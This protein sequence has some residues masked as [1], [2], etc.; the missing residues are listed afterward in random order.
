MI[1]LKIN[2]AGDLVTSYHR[3]L[4][5]LKLSWVL[6]DN[7]T[8]NLMFKIGPCST[9]RDSSDNLVSPL[10]LYLTTSTRENIP[11][12]D[13]CYG[14]DE[15]RQLVLLSIRAA[16]RIVCAKHKDITSEA[17]LSEVH[18]A[19]LE[20]VENIL[21]NPSV[22]IKKEHIDENPFSRQNLNVYIYNNNKEIYNFPLEV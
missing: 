17:V 10:E 21:D 11:S 19:V 20:Q 22:T 13:S 1:D 5:S 4:C 6:T 14:D 7:P 16:K 18:D 9:K 15:L 8:I 3:P 2:N 12:A